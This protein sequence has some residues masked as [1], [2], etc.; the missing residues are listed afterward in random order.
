MEK[1]I[2]VLFVDDELNV[3]ASLKRMLRSKQGEWDM[4]FAQSGVEAL[5]LCEETKFDVVVSDIRMPGMDGAEL[6]NRVK[7]LYP[8]VIRIALSGQVGLNEVIQSLRAV[9]Q[10]IPKPCDAEL[11]VNKIE[12]AIS[13]RAI[14]IDKNMQDMVSEIES[15]PVLPKVFQSIEEELRSKDPSIRKIADLISMDVGLLAK[16]LK[17][18]NSPYFGLPT[19]VKS[20]FQAIT[21]LGLETINALLLST[22]LFSMYD[23]ANLPNFSLNHLWEHSFRVSNIA[24]IIA[25]HE[26]MDKDIVVQVRMAG[27]LHDVGKLIL[28]TNFPNRYSQVLEKVAGGTTSIWES[29]NEVFG[30]THAQ[31]GAYLMGLWGMSAGVVHGI[32]SHH[33]S[34]K[35]DRTVSMFVYVANFIDHHCMIIHPEYARPTLNRSFLSEDKH[36]ELLETWVNC[37]RDVWDGVDDFQTLDADML[38]LLRK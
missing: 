34:G 11:L 37:V 21:L 24:G 28:A 4:A 5:A 33:Q 15:L 7:D 30:T 1:K 3:L 19:R 36:G 2:N 20:I 23:D 38:E 13:L 35:F 27:L 26:K 29:E 17:L 25:K 31:L 10:Y 8:G 22:H 9:H 6:L 14:L 12:G 32:G 18:V 16:I